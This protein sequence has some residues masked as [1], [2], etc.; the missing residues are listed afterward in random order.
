V[1]TGH[2]NQTGFV[3]GGEKDSLECRMNE[4]YY[5]AVGFPGEEGGREA[6]II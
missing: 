2:K 6:G 4:R 3:T 1:S 5:P